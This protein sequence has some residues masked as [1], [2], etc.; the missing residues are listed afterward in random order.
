MLDYKPNIVLATGEYD[1]VGTRP[2]R[3]DGPDKVLGRARYAADINLPGMLYGK[4]YR[5]PHPH[6]RIKS[7]D[8]T[9]ALALPGVKA[10]VTA[11]DFPEVS[12][13]LA[14]QEEG[15]TVNYGFYTRNIMAREESP[16]QRPC[17]SGDRGHVPTRCGTGVGTPR[18]AI[19][20]AAYRPD[21]GGRN[22]RGRGPTSRTV[23]H[24]GESQRQGRR[25]GVRKRRP[26]ARTLP[27]GSSSPPE[28]WRRV[29]RKPT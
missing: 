2:I 12:A 27:T 6:A 10:V 8:A 28:T 3:H 1:V 19:R 4:L 16:I 29:S 9:R 24:R 20:G 23:G 14:D 13:A 22:E 18:R 7:I 17:H 25:A 5:S 26:T 21:R 15:G 11:A